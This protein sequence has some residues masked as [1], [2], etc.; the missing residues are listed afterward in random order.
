MRFKKFIICTWSIAVLTLSVTTWATEPERPTF[1]ADIALLSKYI[2]RGFELSDNGIVIEP[3]ATF[4]FKGFTMNLWGNL[5]TDYNDGD[6]D[7]SDGSNWTETDWTLAYE[8][9]FGPVTLG[10]GYIYYGLDSADDTQE[11]YFSAAWDVLLSPTLTIYRDVSA[12]PSWY[13]NFGISHAFA[14]P[15][16]ITL[17][18]SGSVAYYYSIDEDFVSVDDNLNPTTSEYRAFHNGLLSVDLAIPF[19]KYFTVSPVLSYSFPLSNEASNLIKSTSYNDA[20]SF[21]YGG[22]IISAAF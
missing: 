19:A 1:S 2:W 21:L 20:S 18:L 9:A 17:N 12:M 3:S 8:R 6:P 10:L 16:D 15:K 4:G 14:L 5:D 11:F 7:T 22:I 13:F